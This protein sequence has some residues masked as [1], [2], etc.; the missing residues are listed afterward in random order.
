MQDFL[1]TR[2]GGRE[3]RRRLWVRRCAAWL[4]VKS[5][6]RVRVDANFPGCLGLSPVVC[7]TYAQILQGYEHNDSQNN[8]KYEAH[9]LENMSLVPFPLEAFLA[10]MVASYAVSQGS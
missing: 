5:L 3:G 10:H 4:F 1:K 9:S 8:P 2:E 6:S 7:L